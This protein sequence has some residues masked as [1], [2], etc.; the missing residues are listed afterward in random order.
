[1]TRSPPEPADFDLEYDIS[2]DV[3]PGTP[4]RDSKFV[5]HRV[6]QLVTEMATQ[7]IGGHVL[8]IGCGFGA[9]MDLLRQQGWEAWGLDASTELVRYCGQR[10]A[11]QGG[12]PLVCAIAEALPFR[13]GSLDRIVCQGSLDHFTQ[14]RA[15]MQEVARVLK[16][17]GLAIIA[18]SNYDSL[19][20]RAGRTLFRLK[21]RLGRPV[22]QGRPYW[23]IP[24]NHTFRGTYSV[25]RELGQPYLELVECHGIS[26]LWLFHRWTRLMEA[27]PR[28]LAWSTMRAL[29]RIA[30]R[31]PGLA[32]LLV[33]VWRP[34]GNPG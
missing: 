18:I 7:G 34:L 24:T 1:M 19:S 10:F 32:D 17:T 3:P 23:E 4:H 14:P 27:L 16:P 13:S 33:S 20:C 26:I 15:F 9:Q 6:P 29:D 5:F 31:M 22:H 8:D 2:C 30:Y 12:A 25:L 21:G 11:H 28:P